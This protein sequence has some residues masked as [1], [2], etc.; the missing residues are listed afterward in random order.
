MYSPLNSSFTVHWTSQKN[1]ELEQVVN[2]I[3][4]E[5]LK[6]TMMCSNTFYMYKVIT[7]LL[8]D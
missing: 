5:L 4:F 2:V 6:E 8:T 7:A 1:Q 3:G